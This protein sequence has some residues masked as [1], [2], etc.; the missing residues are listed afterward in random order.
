MH[1][2]WEK[3]EGSE[4][5]RKDRVKWKQGGFERDNIHRLV[6]PVLQMEKTATGIESIFIYKILALLYYS[7]LWI[8]SYLYIVLLRVKAPGIKP[9]KSLMSCSPSLPFSYVLP[10]GIERI[11]IA[12]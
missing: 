11:S 10:L 6:F 2:T 9:L 4:G 1:F 5:S 12:P 7:N 3:I 8:S